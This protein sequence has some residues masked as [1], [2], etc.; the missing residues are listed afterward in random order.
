MKPL[1]NAGLRG[2]L[3]QPDTA[4]D[5]GAASL[6][7][8][9]ATPAAALDFSRLRRIAVFRALQ[10][11]DL[12]CVVP[13]LRALRQAAPQ[14]QIT[15]IG[16]PW[17]ASFARRYAAYVDDFVAFPGFP[18]MPET[19]PQL[20]ALPGFFAQGQ[21]TQFD[22]AL[23]WHGSGG[24]SN[25]LTLALGADTTAGYH[26]AGGFCPDARYFLPWEES[27]HE[28]L[29]FLRLLAFL[30]LP[31]A[32]PALEFPLQAAD[33]AGLQRLNSTLGSKRNP[34]HLLA[35]AYVC[36]HPGARLPS[37]RWP[38]QRF[39][40]VADALARQGWQIVLTGSAGEREIVEAL[41]R[42][43]QALALNLCGRTDLGTL[44]ALVAGARMVL[45]NDT[46]MSHIAVAVGTPSVVVSSGADPLRWAPLD[47][48]RHRFLHAD[49]ECRPCAHAVCPIGHPCALAV[50][51]EQV[52][53]SACAI[54][55]APTETD[56]SASLFTQPRSDFPPASLPTSLLA[57]ASTE[58]PTQPACASKRPA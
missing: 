5:T 21:A 29:R 18:G 13:A 47:R 41:Q 39:A 33:H 20:G 49:L 6:A 27:E 40:E 12:L 25:P 17:A 3:A 24:L 58:P 57:P 7:N 55:A 32:D 30:G 26:V 38:A 53:Q 45:C 2:V 16:L 14:A 22:L 42:A 35:G 36:V 9:P 10:L 37:R 8:T 52:L 19:T 44:A 46:G 1:V 31:Q 4:A 28:V 43:M 56:V 34:A 54:L 51:A 50:S 23:Q 11:G 48:A 15:L